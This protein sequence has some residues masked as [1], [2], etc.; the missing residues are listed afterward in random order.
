MDIYRMGA[1]ALRLPID[2]PDPTAARLAE[3]ADFPSPAREETR[4]L[5][6]EVFKKG[7]SEIPSLSAA[8]SWGEFYNG[9]IQPLYDLDEAQD[10]ERLAVCAIDLGLDDRL[11][12]LYQHD[13]VLTP[14][15]G[16]ARNLGTA[17]DHLIAALRERLEAAGFS[18]YGWDPEA[19][20]ADF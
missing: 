9:A 1:A 7:V 14:R 12:K 16:L 17:V 11:P 4:A 19:L 10:W 2:D 8:W 15:A 20:S 5:L 18:T 13:E 6:V 3:I